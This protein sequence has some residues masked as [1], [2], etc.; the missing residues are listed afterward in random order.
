MYKQ[1]ANIEQRIYDASL[2][3]DYLRCPKLFYWRW[4]RR[5]LPAEEPAPLLFGRV[6]HEALLVWYQTHSVDEATKVFEQLPSQ[7][8]GD[9]RRTKEHGE[10]IIKEYVKRYGSE[11]YEIK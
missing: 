6:M 2:I 11:P 10:V 4:V 7:G 1:I 9:D 3:S 5:L 8:I